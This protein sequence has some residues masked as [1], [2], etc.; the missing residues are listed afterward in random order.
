[1]KK[2]RVTDI[3]DA[4]KYGIE[5]GEWYAWELIRLVNKQLMAEFKA[6]IKSV[7]TDDEF[8]DVRFNASIRSVA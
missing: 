7:S 3:G 4:G 1:M 2:Y 6:T 8:N 5:W